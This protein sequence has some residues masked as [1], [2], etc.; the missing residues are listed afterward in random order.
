MSVEAFLGAALKAHCVAE[1]SWPKISVEI[2]AVNQEKRQ[3]QK[4]QVAHHLLP[5]RLMNGGIAVEHVALYFQDNPLA[6]D[7]S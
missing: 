4:L 3:N 2:R 1:K 6:G 5:H 7:F